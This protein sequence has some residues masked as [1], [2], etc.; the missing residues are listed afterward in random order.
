[1]SASFSL[2]FFIMNFHFSVLLINSFFYYSAILKILSVSMCMC[3]RERGG[4][5]IVLA[6]TAL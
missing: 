3:V 2:Y 4:R 6:D 5:D 1:M